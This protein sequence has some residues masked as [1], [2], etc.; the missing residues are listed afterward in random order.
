MTLDYAEWQI[1]VKPSRPGARRRVLQAP[2]KRSLLWK[3]SASMSPRRGRVL[4]QG[5]ASSLGRP[6]TADLRPWGSGVTPTWVST[7]VPRLTGAL[8]PEPRQMEMAM[9][10]RYF[11]LVR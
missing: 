4:S 10:M 7:G 2:S 3:G 5:V 9:V 6:H 8:W 1:L 11:S